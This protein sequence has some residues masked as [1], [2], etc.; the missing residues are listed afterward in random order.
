MI[1]ALQTPGKK[2]VIERLNEKEIHFALKFSVSVTINYEDGKYYTGEIFKGSGIMRVKTGCQLSS[3]FFSFKGDANQTDT[4]RIIYGTPYL[5]TYLY[6][7]FGL[8]TNR[9]ITW[10]KQQTLQ[11]Y[12]KK[13]SNKLGLSCAK[14][15]RSWGSI[16][17][18][19]RVVF[20]LFKN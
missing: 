15:R 2:P 18:E 10:F 1:Q 8:L 14:L 9:I 6:T 3:S 11:T 5:P 19:I 13:E 7:R 12:R 4:L 16:H 20:H 17:L